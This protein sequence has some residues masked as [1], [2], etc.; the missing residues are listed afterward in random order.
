MSHKVTYTGSSGKALLVVQEKFKIFNVGQAFVV[1]I[2]L[3]TRL[4]ELPCFYIWQGHLYQWFGNSLRHSVLDKHL[5][6]PFGLEPDCESCHI[7]TSC[8]VTSSCSSGK[9]QTFNVGLAFGASIST[10]I[11]GI[12]LAG[13]KIVR[14]AMF[15]CQSRSPLL[16]V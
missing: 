12:H 16:V 6:H 7:S 2:W 1:S 10:G 15:L 8:K 5:G 4:Q 11:W 9:L 14:V 13:N 3:G